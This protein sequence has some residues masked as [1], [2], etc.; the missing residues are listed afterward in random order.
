MFRAGRKVLLSCF[1]AALTVLVP[2]APAQAQP[3]QAPEGVVSI[4]YT[5]SVV[6]LGNT[7]SQISEPWPILVPEYR[8]NV[9]T[10]GLEFDTL[11]LRHGR[12]FIAMG[13]GGST[14]Q[15]MEAL[16]KGDGLRILDKG[17]PVPA[18]Y[19]DYASWFELPGANA[20]WGVD[21]LAEKNRDVARLPDLSI[22]KGVIFR[23]GKAA[24]GDV[25]LFSEDG[26]VPPLGLLRDATQW[27]KGIGGRMP[28]KRGRREARLL[29]FARVF[30]GPQV[31]GVARALKARH[32]AIRV[33][34]GNLV[35][36]MHA[37]LAEVLVD[38]TLEAMGAV[39]FDAVVPFKYELR[40]SPERLKRLSERVPL[41]AANLTPP[42]GISVRPYVIAERQGLRVA[43]VGL[44]DTVRLRQYG[45]LG[46]RTGWAGEEPK[47]ALKRTLEE[48]KLERIDSI[49]LVTNV[50]AE[51]LDELRERAVGVSAIISSHQPRSE[52]RFRERFEPE[53]PER[54][55]GPLPWIMAGARGAE[56]GHLKLGFRAPDKAPGH[57]GIVEA[58]QTPR[59]RVL[60][61]VE[62]EVQIADSTMP[63]PDAAATW[64]RAKLA[65][66]YLSTRRESIL[67]DLRPLSAQDKRLVDQDGDPLMVASADTWS[68]LAASALRQ[69]TGAEVAVLHRLSHGSTT[70]GEVPVSIA[71][72]WLPGGERVAVLSLSG[73]Q[74]KRL[75]A[76][77]T[78]RDQFAVAGYDD[79]KDLVGGRPLQETELYRVA[80]FE[81]L[82]ASEAYQAVMPPDVQ[83]TLRLVGERIAPGAPNESVSP[84]EAVLARLMGMKKRH[85][86]FTDAY[87]AEFRGLLLD[88]GQVFEPRWTLQ[89]KPFQGSFQQFSVSN[90]AP[91]GAVRNSQINTPDNTALGGKGN[92]SLTYE[93]ADVDWENRLGAGYQRMEFETSGASLVQE[94]NDHAQLSS[95]F[96]LK[97]IRLQIQNSALSLIPFVNADYQTEFTPTIDQASGVE[98]ARRQELSGIAGVVLYPRS[99]LKEIRLGAIAKNDLAV[100]TGKFEPGVQV[101]GV[102]EQPL[103][104]LT[105]AIE[106]DVKNYFLTPEDTVADLGLLGQ[107]GAGLQIPLW[108]GFGLRVGVDALV[109]SGKTAANRMLGTSVMPSIGLSYNATWK[110]L[111]GLVY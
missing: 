49:V 76:M 107:V 111:V 77:D 97:F 99:W 66:D 52:M 68:R 18:L 64:R 82:A 37:P 80:T 60:R 109:F 73:A 102:L 103:G 6:G 61:W 16:F 15:E 44:A 83:T 9:T 88:D 21:W 100:S 36:D 46:R 34:A 47:D 5:S 70:L 26:S 38:E 108:S 11:V 13:D 3:G 53:H 54:V 43:I 41:V 90:R 71:D 101:A 55:R 23:L 91:F 95:E 2:V 48:L 35:D 75:I 50:A 22:G 65:T 20:P 57:A 81:S 31:Q 28:I 104:P 78:E 69:A 74:L 62:N 4:V 98:N 8:E 51:R 30:G 93:T 42:A 87:G 56:I 19:S 89:I 59:P 86:G 84:R 67:P 24:E 7:Y 27:N 33:D 25:Y 106:A 63:D 32:A 105:L 79:R 10:E 92:V 45:F 72:E 29:S 12:W 39:G 1:L 85:G 14:P 110:P 58:L 94:Q 17:T 96:R 40:L